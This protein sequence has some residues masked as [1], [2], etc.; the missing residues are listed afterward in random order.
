MQKALDWSRCT[1]VLVDIRTKCNAGC[2]ICFF[3]TYQVSMGIT[4]TGEEM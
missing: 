2:N 3:K 1:V 4:R